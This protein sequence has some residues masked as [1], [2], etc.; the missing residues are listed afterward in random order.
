MTESA[1]ETIETPH[2]RLY[3]PSGGLVQFVCFAAAFFGGPLLGVLIGMYMGDL[4]DTAQIALY[5]PFVAIFF[6]GYGLWTA[7][8]SA[9]AFTGI[10]RGILKALFM[11]IVRR[12]KPDSVHDVLPSKEKLLEMAVKAQ[13]SAWSFLLIAIP[14]ALVSVFVALLFETSVSAWER[15]L[16]IGGGVLAWGWLLGTLGR[17]GL[18]PIMEGE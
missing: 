17:R 9:L 11:L 16:L 4:S 7:R 3:K 15:V 8:L 12:K 10:G 5:L 2:G 18:L 1:P 14:V 13:K 6:L